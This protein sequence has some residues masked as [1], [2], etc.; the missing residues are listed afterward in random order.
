[1]AEQKDSQDN[2]ESTDPGRGGTTRPGDKGDSAGKSRAPVS[3]PERAGGGDSDEEVVE[4]ALQVWEKG[5]KDN[6][7]LED[8]VAPVEF[9]QFDAVPTRTQP[10][11]VLLNNVTVDITVELGRKELTVRE[12]A[13]LKE[14][15]IIELDKL[16]GEPFEL[17]INGR[18]FAIGEVVV[19][20]DNMAF[21]ITNLVSADPARGK[22]TD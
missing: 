12:L 5:G 3:R 17:R 7:G 6:P 20:S 1:M 10:G 13:Q 9:V 22:E 16:A 2:R 21:R 15:D 4:E 8:D 19:M 11:S 14:Q 18:L